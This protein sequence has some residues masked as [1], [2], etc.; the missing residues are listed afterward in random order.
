M[1]AM[2]RQVPQ[3]KRKNST[4]WS[5]PEA[6][7]TVLGSVASRFGPREVAMG[8]AVGNSVTGACV[9]VASVGKALSASGVAVGST[10]T[11]WAAGG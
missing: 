1:G 9:A 6:R 10:A 4:K 11:G 3:V 2:E 8:S 5:S 7:L